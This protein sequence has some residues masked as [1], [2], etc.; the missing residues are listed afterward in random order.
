[1]MKNL[2]ILSL[3]PIIVFTQ[4][5]THMKTK[6]SNEEILNAPFVAIEGSPQ[7]SD[8]DEE[9]GIL[10]FNY[11]K[12]VNWGDKLPI[13]AYLKLNAND[14]ERTSSFTARVYVEFE[15]PVN[16]NSQAQWSYGD[17]SHLFVTDIPKRLSKQGALYFNFLAFS[18]NEDVVL[19][20]GEHKIWMDAYS[21]AYHTQDAKAPLTI[22]RRGY[23]ADFSDAI[24]GLVS[25]E[26]FRN[27][28]WPYLS[29]LT[30]LKIETPAS[31][32]QAASSQ[33][34]LKELW[35]EG[36][37]EFSGSIDREILRIYKEKSN[38]RHDSSVAFDVVK[39][40][41]AKGVPE[42]L[43]YSGGVPQ[44]VNSAESTSEEPRGVPIKRSTYN[45]TIA[46]KIVVDDIL[47]GLRMYEK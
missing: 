5:C 10:Q 25:D 43:S 40:L 19:P 16:H 7:P 22:E 1:M 41:L 32:E 44:E 27:S 37:K 35:H 17:N 33:R 42:K 24:I 45:G 20:P 29:L 9:A 15:E 47:Q 8:I 18:R 38:Y 14:R 3:T 34:H 11:A 39:T 13:Y 26:K 28:M 4:A 23:L 46:L 30:E 12:K 2:L 6:N 36:F 31:P 21:G